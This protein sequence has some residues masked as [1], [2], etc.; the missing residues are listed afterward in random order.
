M[1]FVNRLA[2]YDIGR[3]YM[4]AR[5]TAIDP[6]T[7][8]VAGSDANL[9][10]GSQSFVAHAVV[11]QLQDRIAAQYIASAQG[12]DLD[13]LLWDKYKLPRK[14]AA[15][16]A[17]GL[18]FYRFSTAGGAG[19]VPVGTKLTTLSGGVEYV[20]TSTATFGA[21]DY[22]ATCTGQ[23]TSAGLQFE[24]GANQVRN[25]TAPT[26]LF[27]PSLL[28]TNDAAMAGAADR[29]SDAAYR[30][31]GQS[32]WQSARRGTLAA[33][34]FG[35]QSVPGVASASAVEQLDG[36]GNP[37]RVATVYV[38]DASGVASQ[39]MG[40]EVTAAL[41]DYRA[42]GIQAPVQLSF[43]LL[44][45]VTMQ[46]VFTAG[47]VTAPLVELIR[48]AMVAFVNSTPT[49]ATLYR[50]GLQTVLQRYQKQ[51]LIPNNN[52]IIEPAG[53]VVPPAGQTIRT[54]LAMVTAQ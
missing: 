26:S 13:R 10:V 43:P 4:L 44:Q 3:R 29:E 8:D 33:I 54:T 31:R 22:E 11:R 53:D 46:L 45:A 50:A 28:A 16:A 42:A 40:A 37:A 34:A 48:A 27:D 20:T 49:S 23:S 1:D 51:G 36:M 30:D 32:F 41:Q 25:I 19:S 52:T 5:A 39:A 14:G 47:T 17:G 38:A 9:F 12:E 18:R 21:L 2:L 24:V 35:A 15:A 6:T 7:V